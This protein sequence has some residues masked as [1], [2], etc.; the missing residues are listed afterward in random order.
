MASADGYYISVL[1]FEYFIIVN[2]GIPW[3]ETKNSFAAELVL[4]N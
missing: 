4:N 1:V 3:Y 2:M